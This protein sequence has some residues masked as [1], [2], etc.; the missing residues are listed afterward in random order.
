MT[1]TGTHQSHCLKWKKFDLIFVLFRVVLEQKF[2]KLL[3]KYRRVPAKH[4]N[5]VNQRA[6]TAAKLLLT[7][8]DCREFDL[9]KSLSE[10]TLDI[11]SGKGGLCEH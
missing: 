7:P 11:K 5:W 6:A 8:T 10:V 9:P 1:V 4:N 3:Y 2:Q